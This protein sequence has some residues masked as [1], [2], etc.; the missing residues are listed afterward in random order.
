MEG[1]GKLVEDE[2]MREAMGTKGS[3]RHTRAAVI[4]GLIRE[5]VHKGR[6][7]VPTPK[8]FSLVRCV[9]A[10]R[11]S[12]RPSSPVN[13]AQAEPSRAASSPAKSSW[14]TSRIAQGGHDHQERRYSDTVFA[15]VSAACPGVRRRVQEN[16]RGECRRCGSDWGWCRDASGRPMIANSSKALV[17]PLTGFRSRMGKPFAAGVR[18][19]VS[20]AGS[21]SVSS[22][23]TSRRP[24]SA[25]R[26][27]SFL[28]QVQRPR[29]RARRDLFVRKSFGPARSCGVARDA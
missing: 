17:G 24:I 3:A 25:S 28:S 20:C 2:D 18:L 7:L 26:S 15:T 16:Y 22:T 23:R 12:P 1:A 29:L 21:T 8:A 10:S 5:Y 6:E 14:T 9:M 4:E 11:S 27:L 13:G 19:G